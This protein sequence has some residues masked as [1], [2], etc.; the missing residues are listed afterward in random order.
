MIGTVVGAIAIVVLTAYFPQ[1]RIAFLGGLALWGGLC[2]FGATVLRNFASY[3][4]ALAGYT[5]VV[6]AADT[7]G[8]T[9]GP[10]PEVFWVAVWRTSEICIGIVC[11]GIVLAGTDL[12][13]AQR[14]LAASFADLGVAIAEGFTRMLASA[15]PELPDTQPRRREL[16]RHV[17]SLESAVDQALGESSHLRYHSP[18]LQTAIHGLFRALDGWR[19]VAT[20]LSRLPHEMARQGAETIL[21]SIPPQLGSGPE[22]DARARWMDDPVALRSVCENAVRTLLALP[23]DAPSLRLLADAAAKA[24]DGILD[25]LDGL[26]LLVDAP[27]RPLPDFRL[28]VP[29]WLPALMNATRAFVTIV[30]VELVWLATA[31][32]NGASAIVFSTIVVLVLSP[33]GDLAYSGAIAFA[34][35]TAGAVVCAAIIKFAVLPALETFPAF[36]LAI[37]LFLVPAGFAIARS[38]QPAAVAVFTATGII[39]VPLLAPANKMSYDTAQFYNSALAIVVG[40]GVAP[41]AFSLLPPLPPALRA[42]RL[43]ALT[44]RELRRLAI[45]PVPPRSDD[46]EG[47]VYG[48][49]AAVPDEAEP[50]Q[51]APLLAALSVGAEIIHLRHI[52][53]RFREAAELDTALAAFAQ[54]NSAIAIARLRQLDRRLASGPDAGPEAAIALRTR[55]RILVISDALAEHASYFDAGAP[56]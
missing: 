17:I 2:A 25:V 41:V 53:P 42:R 20:H 15:G 48:R 22:S 56:A 31:W 49:L 3:S 16:I 38:R 29:D 44:L 46:W 33:S 24:P 18:T 4:A 13:G 8:A 52:A 7:L 51:R 10:S 14:R 30:A 5:A 1:S 50:L 11:A 35:G 34:L 23:A 32:P 9:G 54:A 27:A 26:Q 47:R 40:C 43:V 6:I 12:G 37:G 36:C 19:G 39:F 28:S 21:R 55:S 45:A